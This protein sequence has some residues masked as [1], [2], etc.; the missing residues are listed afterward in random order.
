M[1][2]FYLL[3]VA[4]AFGQNGDPVE[5]KHDRILWIIPNY[6][7]APDLSGPIEPLGTKEKFHLAAEDSFDPYNFALAGMYA[8]IGQWQNQYPTFGQGAAG[9]AKRLGGAYADLAI[10]NYLTEAMAPTLLHED[11][12]YFRLAKGGF[13]K[14]TGYALS[15]IVIT[16]TDSGERCFNYAEVSGNAAAAAISNLYYPAAN[17][18]AGSTSQKLG[19]ELATDAGFNVLKEFWPDIRRKIFKR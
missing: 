19:L 6:K 4:P 16:R 17:R 9:Y 14:R 5:E 15:R 1:R 12:R 18:T 2:L 3:L 8:G 13:W 11:P 10:G 7:T